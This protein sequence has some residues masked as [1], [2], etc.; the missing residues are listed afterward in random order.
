MQKETS[1]ISEHLVRIIDFVKTSEW[2]SNSEI[3]NGANVAY[4]TAR[5]HTFNMVKLGLFDQAD[6]FPGH[7]YRYS[8]QADKRNR[9]LVTRIDQAREVL[10]IGKRN[11]S[12]TG[13]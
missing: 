10:A 8:E 12:A 7:R 4:R 9:A 6:V 3:A 11:R 5:L 2:C 1:E 13:S